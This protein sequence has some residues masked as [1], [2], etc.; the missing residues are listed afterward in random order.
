MAQNANYS[1]LNK[2]EPISRCVSVGS[3]G[4]MCSMG[5]QVSSGS[6]FCNPR[7]VVQNGCGTTRVP[8]LLCQPQGKWERD[9]RLP[10]S[11][12]ASFKDISGKLRAG[13][14][15][16]FSWSELVNMVT[17]TVCQIAYPKDDSS[18][19][20][21]PQCSSAVWPLHSPASL[22]EVLFPVSLYLNLLWLLWPRA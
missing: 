15:C 10:S 1:S 20:S 19:S 14:P 21:S 9:R 11:A 16:L 2:I 12:N 5:S 6:L 4:L 8:I 17:S 18:N 3:S 7:C 22:A 13:P